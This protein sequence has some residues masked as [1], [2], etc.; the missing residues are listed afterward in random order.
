MDYLEILKR[1]DDPTNW[2]YAPELDYYSA[3]D[4]FA[5]FLADL[6]AGL[7]ITLQAETGDY[8]QDASFHSQIYIPLAGGNFALMRFSNF[9]NMVTI[10]NEDLLPDATQQIIADLFSQYGYLYI[11]ARVL[12]EPYTGSN[13]EVTSITTWWIR[14]FDWV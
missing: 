10:C 7:G 11:P 2:E 14:Y 3:I 13:P 8:I 12:A 5:R 6:S 1:Y 4:Q 9:G